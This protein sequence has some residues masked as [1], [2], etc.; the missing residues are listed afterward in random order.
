MLVKKK[1]QFK[2]S[3]MK[4][5]TART[6]L[7]PI[8]LGVLTATAQ[9]K[10]LT[11]QLLVS[12]LTL[13]TVHVLGSLTLQLNK[14]S[15]DAIAHYL[16]ALKYLK[17]IRITIPR[18]KLIIAQIITLLTVLLPLIADALTSLTEPTNLDNAIVLIELTI[19]Q[20]L[21]TLVLANVARLLIMQLS[22][23]TMTVDVAETS[24]QI[25]IKV[26]VDQIILMEAQE[27]MVPRITKHNKLVEMLHVSAKI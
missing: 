17:T 20:D 21:P 5:A 23:L 14:L 27:T 16:N 11:R 7:M 26:K 4:L 9:T 3:K 15:Q 2:Y 13:Q 19:N 8:R 12:I 10:I 6:S 22:Y 18:T 24:H 25:T 1:N